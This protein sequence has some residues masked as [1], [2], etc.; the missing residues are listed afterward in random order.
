MTYHPTP[1]CPRCEYDVHGDFCPN[2]DGSTTYRCYACQYIFV[3]HPDD[4]YD[5][6]DARLDACNDLH[7]RRENDDDR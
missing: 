6:D 2:G 1:P 5:G 7:P 3:V 4:L